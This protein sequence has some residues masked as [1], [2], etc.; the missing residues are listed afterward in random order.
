MLN[1][2]SKFTTWKPQ[3][4]VLHC[5][6][7]HRWLTQF[8]TL[9][10][11]DFPPASSLVNTFLGK[12]FHR[13]NRHIV[14]SLYPVRAILPTPPVP[15]RTVPAQMGRQLSICAQRHQF[16]SSLT[17]L[18]PPLQFFCICDVICDN[19][20]YMYVSFHDHEHSKTH[21][22]SHVENRNKTSNK[23]PAF[24]WLRFPHLRPVCS[25]TF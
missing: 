8:S 24:L 7:E 6:N 2:L 9:L 19:N 21:S 18:R 15:S 23:T 14:R 3:L 12:P 16:L 20:I 1:Y 17:S 4:R 5:P 13:G 22:S 10:D 11:N 25:K